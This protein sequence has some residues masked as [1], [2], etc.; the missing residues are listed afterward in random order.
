MLG[1]NWALSGARASPKAP[2]SR[3]A[4]GGARS[5]ALSFFRA[6]SLVR[7]CPCARSGHP[8]PLR[9]ATEGR[10]RAPT[11]TPLYRRVPKNP[12]IGGLA[13]YRHHV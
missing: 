6:Y 10:P 13:S 8:P 9:S 11:T 3:S 2:P 7:R 4:S 1:D 5:R 12:H